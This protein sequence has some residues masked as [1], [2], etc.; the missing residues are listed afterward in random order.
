MKL[1]AKLADRYTEAFN[2]LVKGI[3]DTINTATVNTTS[4]DNT[5]VSG[6]DK[7]DKKLSKL[8]N[9]YYI[10]MG[11]SGTGSPIFLCEASLLRIEGR[12]SKP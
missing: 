12:G 11:F 8:L 10:Y 6:F 7:Y 3:I 4:I 9:I 1:T 2:L 5:V